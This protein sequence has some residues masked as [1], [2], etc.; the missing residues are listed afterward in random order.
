MKDRHVASST[1]ENERSLQVLDKKQFVTEIYGS[2]DHT[3][4]TRWSRPSGV[5][6]KS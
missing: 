1:R 4:I 5:M 6:P 2:V 3:L